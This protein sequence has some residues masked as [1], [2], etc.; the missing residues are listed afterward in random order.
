MA[1]YA[2]GDI[3]GCFDLFRRLLDK[4]RFDDGS[5]KLWLV[6]DIVNRGPQ[7][8]ETLRW[9]RDNHRCVKFVLGN[10]DFH[11]LAAHAGAASA[12]PGDTINDI[13]RAPDADELCEWLRRAPLAYRENG[14]LMVHAGVLP[15]WDADEVV[16]LAEET[17]AAVAGSEWQEFAKVLYGDKPERWL[18]SLKGADRW[19]VVINA[20]TRL[21][22]CEDDGKMILKFSGEPDKAPR[23][24]RPWFDIPGRKTRAMQI[25]CGHWAAL[26]LVRR[27]DLL[28]MDTG[29]CWRGKLTAV[30]FDDNAVFCA[31]NNG[32]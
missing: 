14:R 3:H 30:R 2:V 21:R 26:G 20:L 16:R 15:M 32:C 4:I 22:V 11:L 31:Q 19:R 1:T 5:D 13:L 6:G 12:Q 10:H 7:S 28:A 17:S 24:S 8:L 25:V 9:V 29:A 27:D 18:P 23:G